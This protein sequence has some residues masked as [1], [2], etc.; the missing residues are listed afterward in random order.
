M[1]L[2]LGLGAMA[3]LIGPEI[4][5]V[6]AAPLGAV[7]V[8]CAA[9]SWAAGT[10]CYKKFQWSIP[11]IDLAA[12]QMFFGAVPVVVGAAILETPPDPAELGGAVVLA[13]LYVYFVG[14]IYCVWAW[15]RAL[16]LLPSA[17]AAIGTLLNPVVGVFSAAIILD[18]I[19]TWREFTALFLVVVSIAI[20]VLGPVGFRA[21]ANWRR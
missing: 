5:K 9:I 4:V 15:F 7:F 18:E 14:Q 21:I 19:L 20:V 2:A 16:H 10:V 8:L 6:G 17:V 1:G 11:T 3:V 12:W 13:V